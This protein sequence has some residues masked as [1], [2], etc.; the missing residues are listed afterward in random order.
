ML[1]WTLV[2]GA[3]PCDAPRSS[4]SPSLRPDATWTRSVRGSL[5]PSVTSTRSVLPPVTRSTHG[6]AAGRVDGVRRHDQ[7]V[8]RLADDPSFGE[9]AGDERPPVFGTATKIGTCRVV[10]SACGAMRSISPSSLLV[11]AADLEVD[12]R[13]ALQ[14]RA[15]SSDGT[16]ASS[17]ID[18]GSMIVKARCRR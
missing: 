3:M 12:H 7:A 15:E 11:V 9:Q 17:R 13:A 18:D 4:T 14:L 5:S 2:P 10:G 1:T 8:G 6:V 16:D